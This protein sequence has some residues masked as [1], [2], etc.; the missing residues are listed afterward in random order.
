MKKFE[1]INIKYALEHITEIHTQHY[2]SDIDLD[3]DFLKQIAQSDNPETRRVFWMCRPAGTWCLPERN[4]YLDGTNEN[5]TWRFY[6]EQTKDR[7]LAY[8]IVLDKT[9]GEALTGNLYEID[10]ETY[11]KRIKELAL[12]IH[13]ETKVFEDGTE[14][15]TRKVERIY[16]RIA[17]DQINEHGKFLY[18][19]HEPESEGELLTILK[20]ERMKRDYHAELY[21]IEKYLVELREA[22]FISA[23]TDPTV[24]IRDMHAYGYHYTNMIPVGKKKAID[25]SEAGYHIYLL[26]PDD[27]EESA[28]ERSDIENHDGLFGC[29]MDGLDKRLSHEK[30]GIHDELMLPGSESDDTFSIYQLKDSEDTGQYR[31]E[32]FDRLKAK[33]LIAY[34][35]NYEHIYTAALDKD[36]ILESIFPKFNVDIPD[37]FIGH[38]LSV[39]DIVL[40]KKNGEVTAHYVD[41]IGFV[42]VP[43]FLNRD[44]IKNAELGAEQNFD[45]IDGVINN[46]PAGGKENERGIGELSEKLSVLELL[47]AE[48]SEVPP[49]IKTGEQ[50]EK[51]PALERG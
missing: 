16:N 7:I 46:Q 26:F 39:S 1:N 22:E 47:N 23:V 11:A 10:Y 3:I 33:G 51:S 2:R 50:K 20:R 24:T 5:N 19:K 28:G 9:D 32:S 34:P 14:L 42:N 37:G 48:K 30:A 44:Y 12:P 4:V 17:P 25:L 40:L 38:A 31:W 15:R 18:Y 27:G 49:R 6:A 21:D 41:N 13:Y 8:A 29:E 35:D 43:E 36:A 45:M